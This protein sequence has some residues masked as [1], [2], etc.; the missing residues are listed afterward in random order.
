MTLYEKRLADAKVPLTMAALAVDS[1]ITNAIFVRSR[2]H[3]H[4]LDLALCAI[5]D[6]LAEVHR[7]WDALVRSREQRVSA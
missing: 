5:R 3:E 2:D 4:D 1:A 6:Q 7:L